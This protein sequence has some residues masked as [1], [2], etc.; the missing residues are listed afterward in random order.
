MK[1]RILA[2][3]LASLTL[4]GCA[5]LLGFAEPMTVDAADDAAGADAAPVDAPTDALAGYC[6]GAGSEDRVCLTTAPMGSLTI[7]TTVT[8][9]TDSDQR[10]AAV[11][12]TIRASSCVL[13]FETIDV[14]G[15]GVVKAIGT[16]PLVLLA[17]GSLSVAGTIDLASHRVGGGSGGA[18]GTNP[19]A[20]DGGIVPTMGGGGAGG[21]FSATGGSGGHNATNIGGTPGA[22]VPATVLRGGCDGQVGAG[23]TAGAGGH[24]GGA[25]ALIAGG[26]VVVSGKVLTSGAGAG[27]AAAGG[28]GGGGGG[29]G[30]MLV[31]DAPSISVAGVFLAVGGGGGEGSG[32]SA[33]GNPGADPIGGGGGVGGSGSA[34]NGGDGGNGGGSQN[35]AGSNGVGSTAGSGGGGGGVGAIRLHGAVTNQNATFAPA[36]IQL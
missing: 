21:S 26:S 22:V 32:V 17:S 5:Q 7:S 36:P 28:S 24:G 34:A 15:T 14:A 3:A 31:L 27:G 2:V 10:C 1:T 9:D 23:Q 6:F 35:L 13:A 18:A 25:V 16:R 12:G 29:S 30:G 8:I 19:G 11:V 4:P 20:C 33:S